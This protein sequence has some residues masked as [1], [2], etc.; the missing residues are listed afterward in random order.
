MAKINQN[1]PR[2]PMWPWGGPRSVRERLVEPSQFDRKK[3][4]R[5]AGNPKNPALAS[6][7]LLDFIGPA[8]SADELR[9]PLPPYPEGHD[10]DLEAYQDRQNLQ[11]AAE[12][13]DPEERRAIDRA[14]ARLPISPERL[15]RMKALLGREGQMLALVEQLHD[16][17][18]QIYRKMREEQNEEAY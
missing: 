6:A 16:E 3:A 12:K 2:V 1:P 18:S 7:A 15:D 17:I 8:H 14:L 10:A 5:K 9:L 11:S 13:L 4:A